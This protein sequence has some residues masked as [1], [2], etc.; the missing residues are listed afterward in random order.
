MAITSGFFNS[1]DG[2]RKYTPEDFGH[3]LHGLVS[4]GV[5]MENASS[6]QVL[7]T[8]G[9]T[10]EVQRGRAMLDFHWL[11]NDGPLELTLATGGSQDRI[12]AIVAY[13][14]MG[15][16]VCDIKVKQ[17][18]PAAAP[19]A[20]AMERSDVLKEYM[21][22][23]VYVTKL[24]TSVT[25]TAITDTRADTTVCGF[26]TGL[27]KQVDTSTLFLQWQTAYEEAYA[28][29]GDYL[30]AQ[31]AAWEAFFANVTKDNVLPAPALADAGKIPAVNK[32]ADGYN[33]IDLLET[34]KPFVNSR[35]VANLLDNSDFTNP[36]NQRGGDVYTGAVYTIDRWKSAAKLDVIVDDGFVTL[37]CLTGA[38]TRNALT[39]VLPPDRIPEPG[40]KVTL[41]FM[42]TYGD[43]YIGSAAWPTSGSVRA[44]GGDT[45]F[46]GTI[47][48]DRIS[49]F[50]PPDTKDDFVWAALYEGEY[51]AETLPE[52]RPKGYTTELQECRRYYQRINPGYIPFGFGWSNNTTAAA[53]R[54]TLPCSPMRI[55]PTVTF[56]GTLSNVRLQ[57]N[58]GAVNVASVD[59]VHYRPGAEYMAIFMKPNTVYVGPFV[60]YCIS[61][62][63]VFELSADL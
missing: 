53:I 39:Q 63:E 8:D 26:V 29:L 1:V 20:P 30:A 2:D 35:T 46:A 62:F 28:D 42:N 32:T 31:R 55:Q 33:L 40:T 56:S 21:L 7:A 14:D 4:S 61:D 12:D 49:F 18:T 57:F 52:Y 16:R 13:V 43:L 54:V 3:F 24:S 47:Y 17:G 58:Q 15:A 48:T 10:V 6:L 45:G 36:V 44:F 19:K 5:Y 38:S 51:T 50:V 22:A 60:A 59:G 34:L 37:E 11:N 25:Q 41:A 9:M 27:I 23:K